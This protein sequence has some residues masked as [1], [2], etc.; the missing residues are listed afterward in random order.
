M[1]AMSLLMERAG[2]DKA[3][4]GQA[5]SLLGELE[6]PLWHAGWHRAFAELYDALLPLLRQVVAEPRD[7]A[8]K[9]WFRR[10]RARVQSVDW[11][12][13]PAGMDA[14]A[15]DPG[16][17]WLAEEE[18]PAALAELSALLS[19]S[20]PEIIAARV[21][22]GLPVDGPEVSAWCLHL[23]HKARQARGYARVL[24]L[25]SQSSAKGGEAASGTVDA[26]AWQAALDD[27]LLALAHFV[28]HQDAENIAQSLTILADAYSARGD[29]EADS[30]ALDFYE[31]AGR[32]VAGLPSPPSFAQGVIAR[33]LGNHHLRRGR[34]LPAAEA[35]A[36]ARRFL[37]R[38]AEARMG[39]LL[40]R[41]LPQSAD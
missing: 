28:A 26:S 16:I 31:Q 32:L 14:A 34:S 20:E 15:S 6:T 4:L 29:A 21:R 12:R 11:S 40:A 3:A 10:A 18:L 35:Y 36:Q 39:T 2:R 38:S 1:T 30:A 13:P 23:P 25:L 8:P 37:L 41:L 19:L 27:I 24:G 17:T 7:V 9:L 22:L 33:S 5:L